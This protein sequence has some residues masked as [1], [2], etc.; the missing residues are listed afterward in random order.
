MFVR[1]SV[2][3]VKEPQL[4]GYESCGSFCADGKKQESKKCGRFTRPRL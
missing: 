1:A 4:S 3:T 2:L